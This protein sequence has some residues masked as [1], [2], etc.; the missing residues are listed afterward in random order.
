MSWDTA[1]TI[2]NAH[3]KKI[4][5]TINNSFGGWL[6]KRIVIENLR[7]QYEEDGVEMRERGSIA[8]RTTP[9]LRQNGKLKSDGEARRYQLA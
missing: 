3:E 5:C 9:G 1:T 4:Y 6:P 2:I 7:V 8:Y